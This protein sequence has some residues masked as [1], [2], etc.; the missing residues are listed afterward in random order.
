MLSICATFGWAQAP[1]PNWILKTNESGATK[2]YIAQESIKLKAEST[3]GFSFK[4]ETGKSFSAKIDAGLLFPPTDNTYALPNGNITTDPTLGGVVGSI[5]GQFNVGA[6]GGASYSIPIE[7]PPGINGM[8]PNV[9]LVY[10]SQ[11]GN[12]IAGWGWNI[13]GMSTIS[14]TGNNLYNDNNVSSPKLTTADNLMLDGQRLILISSAGSNLTIGAKYRTEI[15]TYS[16]ITYKSINGYVCFEVRTKEGITMEF[17]SSTNSYIEAQNSTEALTWL[18]TKVTDANGNYMTYSYGED[19]ANGEFWLDK[20]KYTCNAIAGITTGANEIEF[21]YSTDRADSQTSYIE[22]KKVKQSRLLQTIKTKTNSETQRE[23]ALTYSFLDGFYNKLTAVNEKGTDGIK[24]NP[25]VIDWNKLNSSTTPTF[26]YSTNNTAIGTLANFSMDK[27][28]IFVDFD[29]DGFVDVIRPKMEILPSY[30][31]VGWEMYK[32]TN[33]GQ[34][35]ILSQTENKDTEGNPGNFPY[36]SQYQ[37]LPADINGDGLS[38]IVEIRN[39]TDETQINSCDIDVLINASGQLVRQNLTISLTGIANDKFYFELGDFNADGNTELLVKKSNQITHSNTIYLYRINIGTNDLTLLGFTNVTDD[40]AKCRTTDINGN[41]YPEICVPSTNNVKFLEFNSANACSEIAFSH[42]LN[43]IQYDLE[44]A[45]FNADGKTDV[46][47]YD[48]SSTT[49]KWTILLS[50]GTGFETISCPLTRTKYIPTSDT[51]PGDFYTIKDLNGDGKGDIIE[52]AKNS[53]TVNLYYYNG[54]GFIPTAHTISGASG[55][56]NDRTLPYYDI[57]GDGKSDIVNTTTNSF[58]VISFSTTETE[59]TVSAITNGMNV[60]NTIEYKLLNDTSVYVNGTS[61][62][63]QPVVKLCIPMQ[64]ASQ[65]ITSAGSLSEIT[66]YSYKG[67]KLHTKG[68]GFLGFEEFTQDNVTQNK[69]SVSR[70][71]YNTT[72]FNTYPTQQ[73]I[74]TSSGQPIYT[75]TY[76]NSVI[77]LGGKRIFPYTSSQTAT[78]NLTEITVTTQ[79]SNFDGYGNPQTIITTKGT[80]ATSKIVETSTGTYIQAGSWC[81]NKVSSISSTKL[82]NDQTVTRT[83]QY[84]FDNKGNILT[85]IMDPTDVNSVTTTYQNYD[86]F[87]H[88]RLV[89]KTANNLSRSTSSTYTI[90]GRFLLSKTNSLGE[91]TTYNWNENKSALTSET[92]RRGT[93]RYTY[94]GFGK[95]IETQYPDGIRKAQVL[96]WASPDNTLGAKYYTYAETSGSTP[97]Q[98]WYDGA[99][100]ELVKETYGLNENKISVTTE[101]YTNGKV[102]RISAPYFDQD[103]SSKTWE[104]TYTYDDYGRLLSLTTPLG[105]SSTE[106]IGKTTKVTTPEGTNET[107]V[108]D[109]GQMISSKVNGKVVYFTYYPSGQT[110]TSTP[111]GGQPV[112]MEYSQQGKRTKLI[113][114]DGGTVETKYNGFGELM[115]EKQKIHN[116]TDYVTTTKNYDALKGLP[117]SVVRNNE[118]TS[119]TYDTNNRVS[120]IEIVGKNKQT[121]TYD[122]FDRITNVKEEIGTR[123]YNTSKEY[124]VLGRVKKEIYPSGIYTLN[125]F[126]SYSHLVEVKDNASRSIWKANTENAR[127]QL[128]S[129]NKGSKETTFGFDSRGLP[130]SIVASGVENMDYSFDTKGNLSHRTDN[131]TNQ[132]EQ[133]TYDGMNRLTNWNV[134]QNGLPA[135][136][137]GHTYDAGTGNITSRT[138]LVNYTMSYG[139][140]RP[141]GSDIGPHA[142]ATISGVPANF[143]TA[144]L[145][146]TYTDF[147]K[148]ATLSEG[149]KYYTLA[150]GVDDQR[151]KSEYY[152]NGQSQGAAT[153]TKYYVGNYEEEIN[154]LGNVRKIHYLSGGAMLIQNNG[155]DSLLYAYSDF[156]GS[157]I[158]LTDASGNVV[159]KYAYDP[160]GARRNPTDWTQKDARTKWTTNRGYTGHEHIDA[161]GIINMNGRVYDP[162][163]GMFMSPDPYIQA[164]KDWLNYNRYSYC[165]GNPFKYTDP[166]GKFFLRLIFGAMGLVG[167]IISIPLKIITTG[168]GLISGDK[169]VWKNNW[170]NG[171]WICGDSWNF[172][173]RIEEAIFGIPNANQVVNSGIAG[174]DGIWHTTYSGEKYIK[175]DDLKSMVNYM[176][177]ATNT[178]NQDNPFKYEM[179]GYALINADGKTEYYLLDWK[180][181]T[182]DKS[183]NPYTK[184]SVDPYDGKAMM[185]RF[186]GKAIIAQFH[187]HPAS[188]YDNKNRLNGYDGSSYEDQNVANKLGVPVYSI[189]PHSVSVIKPGGN[190]TEDYFKGLASQDYKKSDSV[191]SGSSLNF[192]PTGLQSFTISEMKSVNPFAIAE[193]KEWLASPY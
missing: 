30:Q 40:L 50:T 54:S 118:T 142:L 112:T 4:A 48:R 168:I 186:D 11:G 93:T 188:Y 61:T 189:G 163:T 177:N 125:L 31:Y 62:V 122:A 191:S 70:F 53:N 137:N 158:A 126:D 172:G 81:P 25:T 182:N 1:Q 34:N 28:M 63:I 174:S 154:A 90:S 16:D 8:Q 120:T 89:T 76:T 124:D 65:S 156:Q 94:N 20:I 108:N 103:A 129:I 171:S 9:A 99:G 149:T 136:Q 17:G 75:N 170:G 111:E 36:Y 119:Y 85:E 162:A 138:D 107:T 97:E 141:D 104:N 192:G 13:S 173:K 139:G 49:T 151:R 128:T 2:N 26:S 14:R 47:R 67:L 59:R 146:V 175:F 64:V 140:K 6:S 183:S 42:N 109:A 131:L 152:A 153:V 91:T 116:A 44:F 24:Y 150:Y 18:L 144:D 43:F 145:N 39:S 37:L 58:S 133:F 82:V 164:P 87:G 166:S 135:K 181:N 160:W 27:T 115:E 102:H 114:P 7:C 167:D 113:D 15:E 134:Y 69:K 86:S 66:N 180:G 88:C 10:N 78:D 98:V 32:S 117:Q 46:L 60:K 73:T 29:N 57:N 159:E 38:D 148:I 157:L 71:G 35:F 106:Y 72:Y 92:N 19:N 22:G 80:L 187:T 100:R 127:R 105:L 161:F 193:T 190:R 84:T 83:S 121:F 143:P 132:N 21:I 12:G 130:I 3:S 41:G 79:T 123:V 77:S 147:K 176:Y 45:D 179:V 185:N 68:K 184:G 165:M 101:Y 110:K 55:F 51:D 74:F 169:G 155:V 178:D 23:Y 56:F 95:L 33:N 96:Q 5:P 52:V